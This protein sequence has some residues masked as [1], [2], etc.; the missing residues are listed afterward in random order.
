MIANIINEVLFGYLYTLED[1]D[2]L[3][4]FVEE[5][6][7]VSGNILSYIPISLTLKLSF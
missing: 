7:D 2:G 6:D 5:F 3:V 4:N 1:C